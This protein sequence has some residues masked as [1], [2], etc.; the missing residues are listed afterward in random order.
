MSTVTDVRELDGPG[1]RADTSPTYIY[2]IPGNI[3]NSMCNIGHI[4]VEP[5]CALPG[6][7]WVPAAPLDLVGFWMPLCRWDSDALFAGLLFGS[8][9]GG[10]EGTAPPPAMPKQSL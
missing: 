4:E 8:R 6:L 1:L 2:V 9:A 7:C 3:F 5:L 10:R